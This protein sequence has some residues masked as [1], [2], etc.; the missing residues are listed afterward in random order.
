MERSAESFVR[1]VDEKVRAW[2]WLKTDCG[3]EAL[4]S[5]DWRVDA[6]GLSWLDH[7]LRL[8]GVAEAHAVE[9]DLDDTQL[10]AAVEARR[11]GDGG[12]DTR[13]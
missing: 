10:V 1:A 11:L 2:D 13:R 8:G 7:D 4:V 6:A 3:R 5:A 9:E 12:G